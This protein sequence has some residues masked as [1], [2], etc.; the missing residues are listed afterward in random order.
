MSLRSSLGDRGRLHSKTN[1]QKP[2]ASLSGCLSASFLK[3]SGS[4]GMR[5]KVRATTGFNKGE[6]VSEVGKLRGP[7]EAGELRP[8]MAEGK[9]ANP[10]KQ[11]N[12]KKDNSRNKVTK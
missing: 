2:E 3:Q 7:E 11:K 5:C 6:R 12:W 4:N 8:M 9:R 1:K 10:K